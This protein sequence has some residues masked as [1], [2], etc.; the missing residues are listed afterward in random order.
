[1]GV[2]AQQVRE[3]AGNN[4]KMRNGLALDGIEQSGRAKIVLENDRH[5]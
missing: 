4:T 3:K 2:I 1:M 5:A